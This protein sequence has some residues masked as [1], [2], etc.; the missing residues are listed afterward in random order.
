M[1]NYPSILALRTSWNK[2]DKK[3]I[4]LYCILQVAKRI[5]KKKRV[6]IK[7]PHHKKKNFIAIYGDHFAVYANSKPLHCMPE[8]NAVCQ[9]YLN[10]IRLNFKI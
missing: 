10:K 2:R 9:L 1:A 3:S 4:I 6:N 8:T 5:E 7:S